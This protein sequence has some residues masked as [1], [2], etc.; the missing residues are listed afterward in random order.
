M[1][2]MQ[3]L[4][5]WKNT[6]P[7]GSFTVNSTI[8]IKS[9]TMEITVHGNT[10]EDAYSQIEQICKEKAP[11]SN[12]PFQNNPAPNPA[13]APLNTPINMNSGKLPAEFN[14][15]VPVRVYTT[16]QTLMPGES[17]VAVGGL[18]YVVK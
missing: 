8:S 16:G 14:G 15:K 5:E 2:I 1:N 4:E 18:T 7:N 10:L 9:P 13:Q 6:N 12:Q 11:V 17:T 3:K